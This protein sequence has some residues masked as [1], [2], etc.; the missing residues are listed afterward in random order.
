MRGDFTTPNEAY[1]EH[2]DWVLRRAGELGFVVLLTPAYLGYEGG[3]EGWYRDMAAA[4]ADHLRSYGRFLG[5][6][7]RSFKNIIWVQAGI[8]IHPIRQS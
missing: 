2:A 8:S 3:G 7:Y 1:F 6:R 4:G 5:K